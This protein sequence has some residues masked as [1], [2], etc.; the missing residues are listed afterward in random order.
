MTHCLI[1]TKCWLSVVAV[2]GNIGIYLNLLYPIHTTDRR[3][4]TTVEL[5]RVGVGGVYMYWA[6]FMG[7]YSCTNAYF[8]SL[9]VL[10]VHADRRTVYQ[11]V[12]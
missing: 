6:N 1:G 3:R 4:D 9:D 12:D 2:Y 5:S 7:I 10:S 11:S 8:V